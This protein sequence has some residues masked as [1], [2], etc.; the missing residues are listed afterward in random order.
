MLATQ[1]S[2]PA[3]L[4]LILAIY[5]HSGKQAMRPQVQHGKSQAALSHAPH[6]DISLSLDI[7]FDVCCGDQQQ[8][9][10]FSGIVAGFHVH[11]SLR[12]SSFFFFSFFFV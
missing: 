7:K 5:F 2:V 3:T 11:M 12:L 8:L 9:Q 6:A 1:I 10:L 4:V